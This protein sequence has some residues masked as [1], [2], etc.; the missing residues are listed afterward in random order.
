MNRGVLLYGP[1]AVGKDTVS[2]ELEQ[3]GA[4]RQ[5]QRLKC[6]PGRT[7]GYRMISDADLRRIPR[8][9]VLYLNRLY[10][11]TYVVDRSGLEAFWDAGSIPVIHLGQPEA[12][13][14]IKTRT[15]GVAWLVVDLHCP[16]RELARRITARETGDGEARIAVARATPRLTAPNVAISTFDTEPSV[17]AGHIAK[18][19]ETTAS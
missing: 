2:V 19:M 1:P 14:L 3:T 9:E 12:V 5:F 11:S 10:D 13:T 16:I 15:P 7:T 17:V 6:G 18:C 4:Y 8:H